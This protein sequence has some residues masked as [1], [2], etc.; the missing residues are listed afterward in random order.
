MDT[1]QVALDS[2]MATIVRQIQTTTAMQVAIMKQLA[3][4][5]QQIAAM[6]AAAG[7]GENLNVTA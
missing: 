3:E 4:S 1:S 5:Q 2:S 6:I 7:V